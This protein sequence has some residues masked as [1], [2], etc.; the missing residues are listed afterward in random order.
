MNLFKLF[1]RRNKQTRQRITLEYNKK[2]GTITALRLNDKKG[3][4]TTTITRRATLERLNSSNLAPAIRKMEKGGTPDQ[5]FRY[6]LAATTN[7]YTN[8]T[9]TGRV[10]AKNTHIVHCGNGRIEAYIT[11]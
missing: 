9:T 6:T 4:T 11:Q 3:R 5:W 10:K 8:T 7:M 2:T 1:T